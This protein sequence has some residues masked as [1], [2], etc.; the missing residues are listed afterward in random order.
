MLVNKTTPTNITTQIQV[1][2]SRPRVVARYLAPPAPMSYL[3]NQKTPR[4]TPIFNQY[5]YDLTCAVPMAPPSGI[6]VIRFTS[7]IR[8]CLKSNLQTCNVT[9]LSGDEACES[10][11]SLSP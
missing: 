9:I 2:D 11:P 10:S 6:F 5:V 3:V 7:I 4:L 1:F 8:I